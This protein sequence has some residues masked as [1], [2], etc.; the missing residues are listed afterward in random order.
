MVR[1]CN[2]ITL[3]NEVALLIGQCPGPAQRDAAPHHWR[4]KLRWLLA[5][6]K[7]ISKMELQRDDLLMKLGAL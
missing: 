3:G 4:R 2:W 7:E 5:R 1:V 6:L